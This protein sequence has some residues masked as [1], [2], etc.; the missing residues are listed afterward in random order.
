MELGGDWRAAVADEDLRRA[1]T[2][3][4]FSDAGWETVP[5]P[6]HW[7]SAAA[8]ADTDGPLL[9]RRAFSHGDQ[10]AAGERLWLVLD[11]LY[12]QGDVWLDGTYLG[13]TEGYFFPH[14]F[15][16]TDELTAR[17]E[18]VLAVEVA[19]A[20]LAGSNPGGI[21]RPVRVEKTGPVRIR[22]FRAVSTEASPERAI[23]ALRAVLDSPDA[24]T[25]VLRARVGDFDHEGTHA[26]AA[27]Q[28]RVEWTVT[29]PSP[30]LWWPRALGEQPMYDASVAVV[31]DDAVSHERTFRIGLRQVALRNWIFAVNGERMFLKGALEPGLDFVR[32]GRIAE[33]EVYDAADESGLLLWQ[34]LPLPGKYTRR[35]RKQARRQARE[36]VDLLGPHPSVFL[37]YGHDGSVKRAFEKSDPSRPALAHADS[38]PYEGEDVAGHW[39]RWPRAARFP[40]VAA[41][42]VDLVR[43]LKYRPTGG[44]VQVDGVTP[45]PPVIVVADPFPSSLQPGDALALDVHV[46]NDRHQDLGESTVAATM[47]WTGGS[48]EWRWSG[49]IAADSCERVGTIQ[50]VVPDAPGPLTLH[51]ELAIP[52]SARNSRDQ[53]TEIARRT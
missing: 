9:Y 33:S 13:D 39:A 24:R 45:A 16:A 43:R 7:R 41:H 2:D 48:H 29:V 49:P 51:L 23:V 22:Y 35:M 38:E 46:V 12:Y 10:L 1:F 18:H 5:V 30:R 32:R 20:P 47:E 53:V 14:T 44:Y 36:A 52:G 11:G 6:G 8:F 40:A 21:W 25:V 27:G 17:A 15:E 37:W 50:F 4:E 26:L 34:D 19:C 31:V 3:P 42:Q 28:N